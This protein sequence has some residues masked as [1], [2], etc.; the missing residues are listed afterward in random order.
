MQFLNVL[1][2]V[3]QIFRLI[4]WFTVLIFNNANVKLVHLKL[5]HTD[6]KIIEEDSQTLQSHETFFN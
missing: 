5:I 4:F 6:F 3:N 1:S 2:P